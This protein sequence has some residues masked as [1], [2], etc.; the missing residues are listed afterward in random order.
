[1][2]RRL[3]VRPLAESD[4]ARAR[5]WYERQRD[6]LGSQYLDAVGRTLLHV[7]EWREI[8]RRILG[9]VRRAFV[10]RFPYAV[11]YV[12]RDERVEIIAVLH[13]ARNPRLWRQR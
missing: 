3:I 9:P 5:A 1:M 11:F 2:S 8:Y 12:V 4:I 7:Q 13:V 10:H 6:G